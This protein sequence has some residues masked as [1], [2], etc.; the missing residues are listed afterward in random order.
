VR[1]DG[2]PDAWTTGSADAWLHAVIES[3]V[4]QIEAGGD[5][6]LARSLIEGLH[7]ALLRAG[8]EPSAHPSLLASV[9]S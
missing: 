5:Q 1:L 4:D 7:N 9:E 6:G 8:T 3:D 2:H